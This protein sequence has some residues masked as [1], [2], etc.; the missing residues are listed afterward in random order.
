MKKLI[1]KLTIIVVCFLFMAVLCNRECP[2]CPPISECPECPEC[3]PVN[4]CSWEQN[5][6]DSLT[7]VTENLVLSMNE[8]THMYDSAINAPCDTV[9]SVFIP[10]CTLCYESIDSVNGEQYYVGYDG[11]YYKVYQDSATL[12]RKVNINWI[13]TTITQYRFADSTIFLDSIIT[14]PN[15]EKIM[16]SHTL[17]DKYLL[18]DDCGNTRLVLGQVMFQSDQETTDITALM[19]EASGSICDGEYPKPKLLI[20]GEPGDVVG[21]NPSGMF[22]VDH[23]GWYIFNIPTLFNDI[24]S[25]TIDWDGDC[26]HPDYDPPE[27]AN[28]W[29]TNI[30]VNGLSYMSQDNVD[31]SGGVWWENGTIIMG[32][33]GDVVIK[34]E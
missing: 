26:Y 32:H 20:N 7:K 17:C 5:K 3:P 23:P 12:I 22:V 4:D 6:I 15:G 14:G 1:V 33:N 2:E 13:D 24:D 30:K 8:L 18:P 16:W 34:M 27:D 9:H 31:V 11:E 21:T 19:I 25:I 10:Q 28:L 29:I